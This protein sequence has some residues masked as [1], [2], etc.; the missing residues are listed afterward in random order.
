MSSLTAFNLFVRQCLLYPLTSPFLPQESDVK[1][2]VSYAAGQKIG[3]MPTITQK[4]Y[5]ADQQLVDNG[6]GTISDIS[7]GLMWA[8]NGVGNGCNNGNQLIWT[9]A[10]GFA[11]TLDFAGHTDWRLPTI[12]EL[13]TII[14]YSTSYPSID[15]L[16]INTQSS[17]Y[18][19]ST[20]NSSYPTVVWSAHFLD[21]YID[22]RGKT[23][24]S[25]VRCVRTI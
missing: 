3:T 19:S 5:P 17:N 25:Y 11:D 18:W 23:S 21:G 9:S 15:A 12:S 13:A 10:V 8:Q 16:F 7:T 22:N 20:V 2:A 14:D 4:N 24:A 1:L 6:D